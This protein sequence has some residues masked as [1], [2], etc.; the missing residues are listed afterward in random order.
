MEK[1]K[2]I[3]IIDDEEQDR[4][5]MSIVLQRD[6]YK[7]IQSAPTVK[8]GIEIATTFMPDVI[9]IDVVFP[10]G[11]GLDGFDLCKQFKAAKDVTAKII[12]ITGHLDA[13]N[14]QKAR[15]SH[16]DE[17]IEKVPGFENISPTIS[18][19]LKD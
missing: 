19:V 5:S 14:A 18:N 9:V 17:I 7:N 4:K 8:E 12:M 6:G 11:D 2:K 10:N 13:V 15:S 16:A 1:N 3:L